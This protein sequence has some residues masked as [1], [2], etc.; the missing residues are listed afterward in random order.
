MIYLPYAQ[1]EADQLLPSYLAVRSSAGPSTIREVVKAVARQLDASVIVLEA[2]PFEQLMS[3][4][5]ARPRLNSA[6]VG[7]FSLV[8]LLLATL[9][10]YGTLT[11]SV[12]QRT[13]EFGVRMALGASQSQV[14]ILIAASGLRI[15]VVGIALGMLATLGAARLLRS[16]SSDV[17]AIDPWSFALVP[18]VLF[19]TCVLACLFPAIHASRIDP[20]VAIRMD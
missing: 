10:L 17:P 13:P 8:A 2:R 4:P 9:G 14:R 5:L 18:L 12:V 11:S 6:M 7:V 19:V 1:S 16:V 15:A 3:V 20:L